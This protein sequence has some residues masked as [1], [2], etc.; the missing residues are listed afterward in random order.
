MFCDV[1]VSF[2]Q[3]KSLKLKIKYFYG[4]LHCLAYF[5]KKNLSREERRTW[6][7]LFSNSCIAFSKSHNHIQNGKGK[8][9]L[10]FAFKARTNICLLNIFWKIIFDLVWGG[11][12]TQMAFLTIISVTLVVTPPTER[13]IQQTTKSSD[14]SRTNI[15]II[16]P[17]HPLS[18]NTDVSTTVDCTYSYLHR[19]WKYCHNPSTSPKSEDLE[20]LYSAVA[21]DSWCSI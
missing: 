8:L 17:E 13:R 9:Y 1:A 4:L 19:P 15:Q 3:V 16:S 18:M 20:W 2:S 11:P 12:I 21:Q 10:A 14:Y 7:Y 6:W 5:I